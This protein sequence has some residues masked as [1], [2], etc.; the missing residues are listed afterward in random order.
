[1]Q[2]V[3][4]VKSIM[5]NMPTIPFTSTLFI[6]DAV[7]TVCH[8]FLQLYA[9]LIFTSSFLKPSN[10]CGYAHGQEKCSLHLVNPLYGT[11]NMITS[12]DNPI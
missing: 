3:A 5:H 1:M 11:M 2:A 12:M 4:C 9:L 8:I 6:C 7:N 10:H